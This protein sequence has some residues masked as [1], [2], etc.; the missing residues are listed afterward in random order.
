MKRVP[1]DLDRKNER[2]LNAKITV[3]DSLALFV[4]LN[5]WRSSFQHLLTL[6]ALL[7]IN[8]FGGVRKKSQVNI[9]YIPKPKKKWTDFFGSTMQS[10]K[11][12]GVLLN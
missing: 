3:C 2:F 12:D 6:G 11:V 5:G 10:V 7:L 9:V 8:K 4:S 1:F